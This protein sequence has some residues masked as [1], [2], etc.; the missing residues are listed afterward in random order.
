[1]TMS[2]HVEG[3]FVVSARSPCHGRGGVTVHQ[4]GVP[5]TFEAGRVHI[6]EVPI[7]ENTLDIPKIISVD[8]HVVEPPDL[9]TSR[10]PKRYVETG[11]RILRKRGY[12][13]ALL[14]AER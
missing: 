10:L 8:D 12:R 13:R 6:R 1:M 3:E 4:Y 11:P 9:W 14:D 5:S 7:E 2:V